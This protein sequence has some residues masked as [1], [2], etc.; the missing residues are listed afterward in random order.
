MASLGRA[1]LADFDV[2]VLPSGNYAGAIND[3]LLARVK[4]WIRGG[5]TLITLAEATRW[6]TGENV[7]L[8]DTKPLLKNG[9]LD[10]PGDTKAPGMPTAGAG[11]G[12][13][14]PTD[15]AASAKPTDGGAAAKPAEGGTPPKPAAAAESSITTR[16]SSPIA[17]APTRSPAPFSGSSST[18]STGCR[19]ARTKRP[20][21]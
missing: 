2:L 3:A 15:G 17:S 21:R 12:G 16:R 18:P 11:S 14:K 1:N 5:G 9:N 10:R 7:G 4:E 8:L 6:A 19:L 13:A 20:R